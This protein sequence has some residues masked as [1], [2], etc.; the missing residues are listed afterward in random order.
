MEVLWSY[1]VRFSPDIQTMV[2]DHLILP[3]I[4]SVTTSMDVQQRLNQPYGELEL[5]PEMILIFRK[6]MTW[7]V[8]RE[9]FGK[10]QVFLKPILPYLDFLV[11]FYLHD[12]EMFTKQLLF[13]RNKLSGSQGDGDASVTVNLIADIDSYSTDHT[14]KLMEV[15]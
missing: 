1:D 4:S 12:S 3:G 15:T 5:D 2:D 8:L 11:Y 13:Q 10:L 14:E 9:L 6:S 7:N